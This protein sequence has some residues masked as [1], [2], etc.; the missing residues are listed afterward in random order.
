MYAK[1]P[2]AYGAT[3]YWQVQAGNTAADL[4]DSE[5]WS[6]TM[7]DI[8]PPIYSTRNKLT[9]GEPGGPGD[10]EGDPDAGGPVGSGGSGGPPP[11][12]N[13]VRDYT[14]I[15]SGENNMLTTRRL[16]AAAKNKIFYEDI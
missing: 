1:L 16:I 12:G 10:P 13:D 7:L 2:P 6:F 8:L 9:Y 5:V 11:G 14:T 15:P 3:Y 4:A